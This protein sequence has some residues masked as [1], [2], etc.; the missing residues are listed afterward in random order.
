MGKCSVRRILGRSNDNSTATK[1]GEN[2]WEIILHQHKCAVRKSDCIYNGFKLIMSGSDVYTKNLF[3]LWFSF[4]KMVHNLLTIQTLPLQ[5][6][7]NRREEKKTEVLF[8]L[9]NQVT[10]FKW[11]ET[12]T[13]RPP[14]CHSC[15]TCGPCRGSNNVWPVSFQMRKESRKKT[16]NPQQDHHPTETGVA[17]KHNIFRE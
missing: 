13:D 15:L 10:G 9:H 14:G 11:W 4:G 6:C 8:S 7:W 5:M 2:T 1:P 12:L 17:Q 16:T 3:L